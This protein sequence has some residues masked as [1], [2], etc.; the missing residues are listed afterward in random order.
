MS[1]VAMRIRAL[2][3]DVLCI[4]AAANAFGDFG[5]TQENTGPVP[6]HAPAGMV[7]IPGGEF[8]MGCKDPRGDLCGGNEPMTDARPIHRVRVDAFWMDRTEVTNA[9]FARFVEATGYVTVAERPLRP[10]DFP[11]VP[12]DKLVPGSVVFT[13]PDHAVQLTNALRWWSYVPGANWRHPTGPESNLAGRENHP[14]VHIAH[15]DAETYARWAGKRLPTEA[16]WEFAA[17]GGRAGEAYPWGNELTPGG[18]WLANIWEG[19]FPHANSK[20]DGFADTAPVASFPANGY[21]LHDVAGNVWEWCS[22]W[23]RPDAYA[24]QARPDSAVTNPAGPAQADSFDPQ[25]PGL[26]KRVQRGG[27]Y[28]CTDLYCT[29]YMLGTRGK[30]APDTGSNHLGFRCVRSP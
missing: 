10:E 30:G 6:A 5:P 7:W 21:G 15:E 18:R 22:D 28:L 8:S 20:A 4:L 14:V 29:R 26:A 9:E 27:S 23:Y 13:P 12:R 16:E 11:G 24:Q 19:G 1:T 25:E 17:R 2:G 3:L